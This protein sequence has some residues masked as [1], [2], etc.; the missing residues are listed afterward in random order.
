MDVGLMV[1]GQN[2]MTW[3]RWR[4]IV[5]MA[6]R[7][8]F[9]SL[10]RS[11]HFFIHK[12]QD[13]LEPYLGFAIAAT[14]STR[15]RFGPLVSPV[16]FRQPVMVG[17][18]AAHLDVLSGGRFVMGLGA[19]WNEAEHRAYGIDFPSIGER[20]DRLEDAIGLLRALW[21]EG[22]ATY[23]GRFYRLQ[24]A[25]CLPKPAPGRPPLLIG[26]S[27]ERRTLAL[28]A[29]YADE[30]NSTNL[31]PDAFTHK[32]QILERHCE[33]FDRDPAT[34]RRSMM[35]FAILGPTQG[36]RGFRHP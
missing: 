29:R 23:D 2:G 16:M 11:D 7:L 35:V 14:E 34:I 25:L 12:Q 15:M 1:E 28:V 33:S 31:T 19:G 10:F 30:W 17:R 24:D 3:Q 22:P 6:D 5:A 36:R 27:G 18:M 32:S 4:H 8:G 20:F 13:S 21:A 26:G 9:P